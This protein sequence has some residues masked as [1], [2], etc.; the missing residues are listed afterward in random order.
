MPKI[1]DFRAILYFCLNLW[2]YKCSAKK[3]RL[4]IQFQNSFPV[5]QTQKNGRKEEKESEISAFLDYFLLQISALK[6][7]S[8]YSLNNVSA[9]GV[10]SILKLLTPDPHDRIFTCYI[11]Q[12]FIFDRNWFIVDF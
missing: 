2:N 9:R 10:Y 8:V 7:L 5:S 6:Y 4:K 12:L 1:S 11:C 3:I